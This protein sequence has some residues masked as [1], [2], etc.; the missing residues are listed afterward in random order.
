VTAPRLEIQLGSIAHDTRTLVDRLAR[1]GIGVTGVTK[2]ALG[3]PEVARTLLGAGVR[4]LG[5]LR[6]GVMPA[7]LTPLVAE[8]LRL[9]NIEL[10]GFGT[11]LACRSGVVPDAGKMAELSGHARAI[12]RS[13]VEPSLPWGRTAEAAFGTPVAAVDRGSHAQT[14]LALGHQD[15]D[16]AGLVP[17]PGTEVVG[18]SSDHLVLISEARFPIGAELRFQPNDSALLRAMTSDSVTK[19][20]LSDEPLPVVDPAA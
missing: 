4:R 6:E 1:R 9:P 12:E 14:I 16:P 20:C 5:D 2:V 11:N 15:V 7:D 8:V 18:A 3:N 10:A 17:P 13:K 19:R